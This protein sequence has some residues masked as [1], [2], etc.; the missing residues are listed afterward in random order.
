MK[1][2]VDVG[3][4]TSRTSADT[5]VKIALRLELGCLQEHKDFLE[6]WKRL[7]EYKYRKMC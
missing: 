7:L 4:I 5:L 6:T 3:V 2:V 1:Q